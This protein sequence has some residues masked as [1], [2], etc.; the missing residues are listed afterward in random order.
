MRS[1]PCDSWPGEATPE[2]GAYWPERLIR[3][4]RE[5]IGH[6]FGFLCL[7]PKMRPASPRLRPILLLAVVL[8]APASAGSLSARVVGV[9]DGDTIT[10]LDAAKTQHKI[11]LAAIDAPE[12][13]QPFGSRSKENLSRL[14]YGKETRIEWTKRDRYGRLVGT[15]WLVSPDLPCRARPDCP[16]TL[17]AGLELL[18][19][20][21]EVRPDQLDAGSI[22]GSTRCP[23][24]VPARTA[25]GAPVLIATK[26]GHTDGHHA[27]TDIGTLIYNVDGESLLCD[28]GRGLY[29]KD[30]FRQARYE[31][32][33]C[34]S[35]G[36]SVPRIDGLLQTLEE[37]SDV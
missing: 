31:N 17:D 21:L 34:N 4:A 5:V 9:T 16:K 1:S 22:P 8:V 35:I 29:S 6:A 12:K 24:G 26:A 18:A 32:I 33:F 37:N 11:R 27:H 15:V 14:V 2:G 28:P 7:L 36:H 20:R 25:G 19:P 10:V 3:P 23:T 13:G 30:Y